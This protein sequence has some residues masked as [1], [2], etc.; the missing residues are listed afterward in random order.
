MTIG[1]LGMC[2]LTFILSL[3]NLSNNALAVL[4]VI[5]GISACGPFYLMPF[6]DGE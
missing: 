4:F 6:F 1:I 2:A 5:M 3:K